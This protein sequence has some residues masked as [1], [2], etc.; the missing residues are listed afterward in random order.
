MY[1]WDEKKK[2]KKSNHFVW[3][4]ENPKPEKLCNK[5]MLRRRWRKRERERR[6]TNKKLL[7]FL[8]IFIYEERGWRFNKVIWWVGWY[9]MKKQIWQ[10]FSDYFINRKT[11]LHVFFAKS[12]FFFCKWK[13]S[14]HAVIFAVE[15]FLLHASKIC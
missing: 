8:C 3:V 14:F 13:N 6:K 1:L 2:E 9:E 7:A 12:F 11:F 15:N 5:N 4:S 10:F